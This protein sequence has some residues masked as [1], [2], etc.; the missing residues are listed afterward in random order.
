VGETG[1]FKIRG[2]ITRSFVETAEERGGGGPVE[3]MIVIENSD[4]HEISGG[5][6]PFSLPQC[7]YNCNCLFK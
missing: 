4:P 3:T 1:K 5:G 7:R 2:S 6:K